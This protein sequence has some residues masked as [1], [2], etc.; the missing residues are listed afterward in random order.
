MNTF[1]HIANTTSSIVVAALLLIMAL[2]IL[3]TKNVASHDQWL[4]ILL[5][6][7]FTIAAIHEIARI[8]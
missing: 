8:T 2:I 7:V 1:L 6:T 5:A 4:R 3:T